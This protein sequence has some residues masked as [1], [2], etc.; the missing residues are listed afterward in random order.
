M[1][2]S[3][4]GRSTEVVMCRLP[5]AEADLVRALAAERGLPVSRLVREALAPVLAGTPARS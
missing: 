3:Q 1:Q 5:R 2:P 4:S